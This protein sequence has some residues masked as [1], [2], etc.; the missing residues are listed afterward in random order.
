MCDQRGLEESDPIPECKKRLL[1][2]WIWRG[3]IV[4]KLG[5]AVLE[6]GSSQGKGV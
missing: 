4:Y 6:T 3:G 1:K 2:S 5:K